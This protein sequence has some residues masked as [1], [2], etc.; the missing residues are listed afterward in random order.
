MKGWKRA[1][2][3]WGNQRRWKNNAV[4]VFEDKLVNR[5]AFG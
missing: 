2:E 3:I 4:Y 1:I 5:T